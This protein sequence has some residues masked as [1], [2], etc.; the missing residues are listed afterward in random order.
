MLRYLL[1]VLFYHRFIWH[2]ILV[3]WRLPLG[4]SSWSGMCSRR[5]W[6]LWDFVMLLWANMFF[7]SSGRRKGE[8]QYKSKQSGADREWS[9]WFLGWRCFPRHTNR[10]WCGEKGFKNVQLV[11]QHCR[12]TSWIATLRVLLATFKHVLQQLKLG[13]LRKFV[14]ESACRE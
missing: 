6:R 12:K 3:G 7:I 5:F 8:Q 10:L 2:F 11:L 9:F 13:R 1:P 4:K 14:A